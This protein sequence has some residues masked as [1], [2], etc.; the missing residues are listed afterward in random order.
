[1]GCHQHPRQYAHYIQQHPP[2]SQSVIAEYAFEKWQ[3]P[4][5][6]KL[7]PFENHHCGS[8]A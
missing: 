2:Y 7:P 3:M 8:F 6:A 4:L 1:M 5:R